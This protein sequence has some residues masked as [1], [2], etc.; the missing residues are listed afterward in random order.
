MIKTATTS[1][2]KSKSLVRASLELG[3]VL[4]DRNGVT[5]RAK[6]T[7]MY[8]TVRAGDVLRIQSCRA[9]DVS[10]GDIAV[11]RKPGF[12][13]AHRV[14]G[15]GL[16]RGRAYIIT[17][18]DQSQ[19]G[20]DGPTF[21]ESLLGKVVTIERNSRAVPLHPFAHPWPVRGY[22]ALRLAWVEVVQPMRAGLAHALE[23]V[24][25]TTLYR[26]LAMSWLALA[27]PRISYAVR[28]PMPALGDAVYRQLPPET[29]DV[30]TDWRG[31]PVDRWTLTLHLDGNRQPVAWASFARS[32]AADWHLVE[33]FVCAR[34]RG[35]GLDDKLLRRAEAILEG[36]G[37]PL[38][39]HPETK[40]A[41]AL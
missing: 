34:Y 9:A 5:F 19:V 4:A 12:L 20:S 21:D 1:R 28:L 7:C 15:K 33:S 25:A 39:R 38:E 22:Y 11:G 27:R 18:P 14:I 17:R 3:R 41:Y 31:R 2:I 16:E 30:R 36:E 37:D 35:A 40:E 26:G 32:G 13:F 10:V 8:P 24:Q 6:G 29:F 23:S